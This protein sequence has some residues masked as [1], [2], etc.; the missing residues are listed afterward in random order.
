MLA[1]AGTVL[2]ADVAGIISGLVIRERGWFVIDT[3]ASFY[4]GRLLFFVYFL[5]F[6][7]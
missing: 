5:K 3:L 6:F 7:F 4:I 1:L 2:D